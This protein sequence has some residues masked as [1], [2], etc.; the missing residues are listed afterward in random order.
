MWHTD[1]ERFVTKD[2]TTKALLTLRAVWSNEEITPEK[3]EVYHWLLSDFTFEQVMGSV[4]THMTTGTF[5]PKPAELLALLSAKEVP[6][7]SPGEA[8][9]VVQRQINRHGWDG[10]DRV[11]FDDPAIAEAV[12]AVGWKRLCLEETKYVLTEFNRA[13]V[14]AQDRRRRGVQDGTVAI[15]GPTLVALDRG[16][17]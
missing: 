7:I 17:A 1:K 14:A 16:A 3:I 12:K 5:F 13:L 8:W 2:E 10:Y 6:A 11:T 9:E 15:D 4:K